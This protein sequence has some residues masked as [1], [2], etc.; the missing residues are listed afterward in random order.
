MR[1]MPPFPYYDRSPR[2]SGGFRGGS[3][4][5]FPETGPAPPCHGVALRRGALSISENLQNFHG[6]G[7]NTRSCEFLQSTFF[8]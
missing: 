5:Y 1:H 6:F 3:I 2:H 4:P 8:P 7:V